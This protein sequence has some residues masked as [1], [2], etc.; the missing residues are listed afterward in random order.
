[1]REEG[2]EPDHVFVS[3]A[4]RTRETL[5]ELGAWADATID[6]RPEIYEASLPALIEVARSAPGSARRVLLIGHNPGLHTLAVTLA[7]SG[8]PDELR[9]DFPTATLA[10]F[11]VRVPW[12][13]L[14]AA[15]VTPRKVLH[16]G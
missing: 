16:A 12:A 1:M 14:G 6:I 9:A 4:T 3:P 13:E 7:G 10:I 8:A 15:G 5:E 2:L 11:D